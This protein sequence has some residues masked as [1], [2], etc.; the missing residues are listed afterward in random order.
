MDLMNRPLDPY[1]GTQTRCNEPL[2]S[3]R[4]RRNIRWACGAD[5]GLLYFGYRER[6]PQ[7]GGTRARD[8]RVLLR[9]W[10]FVVERAESTSLLQCSGSALHCSECA[11]HR[12]ARMI[13]PSQGPNPIG[14][15]P[16]RSACFWFCLFF[17]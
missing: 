4:R 12:A 17:F 7:A 8:L 10:I 13:S 3:C 5:V 14:T 2:L 11:T 16:L 1:R 9:R 6:A 15:L